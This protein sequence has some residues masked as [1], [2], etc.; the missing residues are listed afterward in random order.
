MD[1]KKWRKCE[2]S[3]FTLLG[4]GGGKNSEKGGEDEGSPLNKAV[5]GVKDK[6]TALS[7]H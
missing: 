1:Q 6:H 2:G 5:G 7:A 3:A 4:G